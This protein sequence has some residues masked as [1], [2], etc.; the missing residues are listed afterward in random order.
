MSRIEPFVFFNQTADK[1]AVKRLVG[2]FALRC[3]SPSTSRMLDDLKS[4]GFQYATSAGVSLGVDDLWV[5]HSK[6]WLI[7]DA[8]QQIDLSDR[9]LEQGKIDGVEGLQTLIDTW[10]STSECL[11]QEM[12]ETFR[13]IDPS[14][15]VYMMAFSGARG[16]VSQVH[17]LV[18]M[19]GLMSDPQGEIIDVPI[20]S[21][22]R[23]GLSL[24]EYIISCYGARKGVVDTALRT[25]DSGYLT[26]RLVDVAQHVVVRSTDCFSPRGVPLHLSENGQRA[27]LWLEH[28]LMGRVLAKAFRISQKCIADR[29][30]DICR[31]LASSLCTFP[32][33]VVWL[34]S[35][36]TCS[37]PISVCQRCYGWNLTHGILVSLG[38]AVGIIAGQSIGEPG[39]QLTM[40]TFH[41]GGVFTG[42]IAEQIRAP[43]NGTVQ[44]QT[45]L[46]CSAR[47]RHGHN[48]RI[49]LHPMELLIQSAYLH[50]LQIPV[51]TFLL[52]E[53]GQMVQSKQ[54]IAEVRSSLGTSTEGADQYVYSPLE[55][56]LAPVGI[57][58]VPNTQTQQVNLHRVLSTGHVWV[59]AAQG[60]R[61]STACYP[62]YKDQDF[63]KSGTLL[64]KQEAFVSTGGMRAPNAGP[65]VGS[66][67]PGPS[68]VQQSAS[69]M[70]VG[71]SS[72]ALPGLRVTSKR[73]RQ[74]EHS[75]VV[76]WTPYSKRLG[77]SLHHISHLKPST[78]GMLKYGSTIATFVHQA[79]STKTGGVLLRACYSQ[80]PPWLL[81]RSL[82]VFGYNSQR[83]LHATLKASVQ[84][85]LQDAVA[86]LVGVPVRST[87]FALKRS[88]ERFGARTK[89]I[90][91][92]RQSLEPIQDVAVGGTR[93]LYPLSPLRHLGYQVVGD[94]H[95]CWLPE[96]TW[97]LTQGESS[98]V[99]QGDIVGRGT[100]LLKGS[101]CATSGFVRIGRGGS[102]NLSA[103]KRKSDSKQRYLR[104]IPGRP[105]WPSHASHLKRR[106]LASAREH[107]IEGILGCLVLAQSKA[108]LAVNTK[109][110]E[111]VC[112]EMTRAQKGK[113]CCL[114][115]PTVR[116]EI[117]SHPKWPFSPA[118]NFL[119]LGSAL[120]LEVKH[121]T[122]IGDGDCVESY[123]GLHLLRGSLSIQSQQSKQNKPL[124]EPELC[125][126]VLG[127]IRTCYQA[128]AVNLC[129]E[130]A[131][132][133]KRWPSTPSQSIRWR[134]QSK[135]HRVARCGHPIA[136]SAVC[137]VENGLWLAGSSAQ[138][139]L[140]SWLALRNCDQI[141]I[142]ACCFPS[143]S[144]ADT[145]WLH[146]S[147]F[148]QHQESP[149]Q[150]QWAPRS[151]IGLLGTALNV[152]VRQ[153]SLHANKALAT[154]RSKHSRLQHSKALHD[155]RILTSSA[156]SKCQVRH[157]AQP[158][159]W[160][161]CKNK[162]HGL[163]VDEALLVSH[164]TAWDSYIQESR[165]CA[166]L[167]L[168][169][170]QVRL[171]DFVAKGS[172][173]LIS[174]PIGQS[175][176]V[177]RIHSNQIV[178][179]FGL[180]YL[181]TQDA[182][183]YGNSG[184]I[185]SSGDPFL[186]LV[187]QKPKTGDI[188][189]GLPKVEQLL[190]AR[191]YHPLIERLQI[192]FE[193]Y[194]QN[195]CSNHAYGQPF[196]AA[197]RSSLSTIQSDLVNAIQRVYQSQGVFLSDRH[198]EIIVRQ[199]TCRARVINPG[200]SDL[201][202]GELAYYPRVEG[203][204]Q[205]LSSGAE[206]KPLIL[207][208]TK[209]ALDTQSFVSEASFQETTRVL[210]RAAIR[211][212]IDWLRGIKE[213]VVLGELIPAGTGRQLGRV[214]LAQ[215][216]GSS[217]GPTHLWHPA[218]QQLALPEEG[219]LGLDA[220]AELLPNCGSLR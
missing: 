187:Y 132:F 188:I 166:P 63:V 163:L 83:R 14:N 209:A 143:T 195:A 185:V 174:G 129:K 122:P 21:N 27:N 191:S 42:D 207:G 161:S 89:H 112:I 125:T 1:S 34:R 198:L 32:A 82:K 90:K 49:S 177:V 76:P 91:I 149:K 104:V 113:L 60:Y 39:T 106:I 11:K 80:G 72:L 77:V 103:K 33:Q 70:K 2:W 217:L 190:E 179:R 55:G 151:A 196:Y 131:L 181:A 94:G 68:R 107:R 111:W 108:A 172:S 5:H 12:V 93:K 130:A 95:F 148:T 61:L 118:F 45:D 119:Q 6:S 53:P 86:Y 97:F 180:P 3:G 152:A 52:V 193:A 100:E 173:L 208:I 74:S 4:L 136:Q 194:K 115:R 140:P 65:S 216:N 20:R 120:R 58:V 205:S 78:R 43:L 98:L 62:A 197:T 141:K 186:R 164:S 66:S 150:A 165:S 199:M 206:Y 85:G 156:G 178:L 110:H 17:Q 117:T 220:N 92:L 37:R 176:Q 26:R 116:Y 18:G 38:E 127:T 35:P 44:Y 7:Q 87:P 75:I 56:E 24:T 214:S 28:R 167:G 155:E 215:G 84:S 31:S 144:V 9:W 81:D 145:G 147:C 142:N 67:R 47:T 168:N 200:D 213:N 101:C 10:F 218:Q 23:E 211:G 175:G 57:S 203:V 13:K 22:F 121:W 171:G 69:F 202:P 48:A 135:S 158:S 88:L 40:R 50:T 46:T 109:N 126:C 219:S 64:A 139:R 134:K 170:L 124:F 160:V 146:G 73:R 138:S 54:V 79:Y 210:T 204:N 137:M 157:D 15:P 182:M 99:K 123:K 105:F 162:A 184:D 96:E 169:A 102:K 71:H 30:E 16:N 192:R 41:T 201:L 36:L 189:Q 59:L 114:V 154:L 25:A 51:N 183:I 133:L 29:N 153:S 212:R 128:L 159:I 19:R 8:E